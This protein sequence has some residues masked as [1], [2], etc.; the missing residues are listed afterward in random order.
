[1][2]LSPHM[3]VGAA[4]G[5]KVNS[6]GA[7]LVIATLLHFLF[8]R[9]PHSE[10]LKKLNFNN[11]SIRNLFILFLFAFIDILAGILLIWIFLKDSIYSYCVLLGMMISILPDGVVFLHVFAR[12][13]FNLENPILK[14]FYLLHNYIHISNEN[15]SSLSGLAI[16]SL[17]IPLSI[18]II[19]M[20]PNLTIP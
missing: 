9:L 15:N 18:Y 12:R 6:Y 3:L 10:Y 8:D 11:I 19:F 4:I 20:G 5:F 17:I 2:I 14:K 16:E 1:M 13:I 7:I